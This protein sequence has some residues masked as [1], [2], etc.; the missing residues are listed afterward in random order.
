MSIESHKETIKCPE[1]ERIQ[2]AEVLHTL[3]WATY[4]HTCVN[5]K[6]TIMESEWNLISKFET[7]SGMLHSLKTWQPYFDAVASGEKNFELR[8]QDRPFMVGD[9]LLLQ[10]WNP[11]TKEYTGKELKRR[12]TY[13]LVGGMFGL[14]QGY[15]ILG[16]KEITS[17]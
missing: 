15:C 12:V 8:K 3:P 17:E 5:C 9:D 2:T 13:I 4:I 7:P 11:T 16:L 10:E 1:C 14:T 6:H